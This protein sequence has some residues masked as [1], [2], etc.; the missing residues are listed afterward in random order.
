MGIKDQYYFNNYNPDN[1]QTMMLF[2]PGR[3][4]QSRELNELQAMQAEL[5]KRLGDTILKDGSI[6]DGCS[7]IISENEVTITKGKVYLNGIVRDVKESVVNITGSGLETI[8]VKLESTVITEVESPDLRDP[9]EGYDNYNQPGAH[10]LQETV[11]VVANDEQAV[12]IYKLENGELLIVED[13]PQIDRFIDIL[14]KRTYDE[15]GNYRVEGF[16]LVDKFM[17]NENFVFVSLEPGRAYVKGYEVNKPTPTTI[18]LEKSK[19]VRKVVNEPKI[20]STGTNLYKLNNFPVKTINKV[21]A[22]TQV[23][24]T[25]TRGNIAG[26]ID[27]L[28]KKPVVSIVKIVQNEQEFTQGV[29]YRLNNDG[30]DWSLDGQEPEIGTS[31]EVTWTYNKLLEVG[32]DYSLKVEK[33]DFYIEFLSGDTPVD[34]TSFLVDYEFYLSRKDLVCLDHEGRIHVV[35]GQPDVDKYATTPTVNNPDWLKVGSVLLLANSDTPVISSFAIS[36]YSM[37]HLYKLVNRIEDLEYNQA[38]SNLDTEAMEGEPATLLKGILTDGFIGFTKADVS[39]PDFTAALDMNNKELTLPSKITRYVPGLKTDSP[40]FTA[41]KFNRLLTADYVE[42]LAINQN[43]ATIHM[44]INPYDVFP[45]KPVITLNPSV[46]NWIEQNE[47]VVNGKDRVSTV[48]IASWWNSR[49]Q[50]ELRDL[51]FT[52]EEIRNRSSIQRDKAVVSRILD[53][54]IMYMRQ[55]NV[56]INVE[57]FPPLTDNIVGLFDGKPV[58]LIPKSSTY[59]GT[60]ADSL[61]SDST[62][63]IEAYFTIPPG[64]RTGTRELILYPESLPNMIASTSFTA[65]GRQRTV[66]RTVFKEVVHVRVYDPLA[67]SFGFETDRIITSVG[68]YFADKDTTNPITIQIRSMENGL[69]GTIVY[70]EKVIYPNEILRST[71]S[72]K[73]TKITLDDP[74]FCKA[75]TQ[76][77]IVVLSESSVDS[78]FVSELGQKDLL[79][80]ATVIKQPYTDGVLFSS[81]NSLTWTPHQ[82]QDLKFKIYAAKFSSDSKVIF[83]DVSEININK[84]MLAVDYV[85]PSGTSILWEYNINDEGWLPIVE[86]DDREL[87]KIATKVGLRATLKS[88]EFSSPTIALDSFSIIGF[89][90]ELSS[91]YVS[92]N[93]TLPQPYTDVKQSIDLN[94]PVGTNAIIKFATDE[95]GTNWITPKNTS[96]I[97]IS[98]DYTRYIFTETLSE[99]ATNFRCRIELTTNEKYIRPKAKNLMNILK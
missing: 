37:E 33:D 45:Q 62:G 73:E 84:L 83:E 41:K 96:N 52:D 85:T 23:T 59:K 99:P 95:T 72:S 34:K 86:Y 87:G 4:L 92:K 16:D 19:D 36:S 93:V 57:K 51:G 76:Y 6:I 79:T 31:Y 11:V 89:E 47:I 75:N 48:R 77:C 71:D 26:G 61:K 78:L 32:V 30:V 13:K 65:N 69:P 60:K 97:P 35:K 66:E 21:M 18:K 46:D 55:I 10:R 29:D 1:N 28:N 91:V 17:S 58:K 9:A 39:H 38:I 8:G 98:K 15:S 14:A 70:S 24:Q 50:Q 80:G 5:I 88:T 25:V 53:N 82:T 27:Y 68:L 56:N 49:S 2:N 22:I 43:T 90:D 74:V 20:Y 54:S 40:E 3:V 63:K 81:S 44:R 67:Q 94:I 7:I 42:T 64:T 12:P